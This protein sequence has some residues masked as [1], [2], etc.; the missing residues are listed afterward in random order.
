MRNWSVRRQ[1]RGNRCI[2][3]WFNK[4]HCY[5]EYTKMA[6]GNV[7]DKLNNIFSYSNNIN[8]DV[9]AICRTY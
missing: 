8:K 5:L 1:V 4:I 6:I 9:D 2:F 3:A 7:T